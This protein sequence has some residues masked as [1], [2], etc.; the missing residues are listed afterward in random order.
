MKP[1]LRPSS[2]DRLAACPASYHESLGK[3]SVGSDESALGSARHEAMA[4]LQRT[5]DTAKIDYALIAAKWHVEADDVRKPIVSCGYVPPPSAL[6]EHPVTMEFD[7]FTVD[8]TADLIV[9]SDNLVI[10]YKFTESRMDAA[11]I[12]ERLQVPAYGAAAFSMGIVVTPIRVAVFNPLIGNENG[13]SWAEINPTAVRRTVEEVGNT[14]LAQADLPVER[15]QYRPGDWCR[16]CPGEG[17]CAVNQDRVRALPAV[18]SG[19]EI[20]D[21][22]KI[23]DV[24]PQIQ[25]MQKKLEQFKDAVKNDIL[26]N[27]AIESDAG[28]LYVSTF[29]RPTTPSAKKVLEFLRG[30]YPEAAADVERWMGSLAPVEVEQI[31]FSPKKEVIL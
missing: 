31:K 30:A 12:S 2:L 6:A 29:E 4:E 5:Q 10:D 14:A 22:R 19:S 13:W 3:P 1:S 24:Y 9:P 28:R 26:A 20:V 18:V 15:R 17:T 21:R 11:T 7:N 25:A 27:G 16:Y 8:G 23:A